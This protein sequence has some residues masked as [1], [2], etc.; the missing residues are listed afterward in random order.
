MFVRLNGVWI[1]KPSKIWICHFFYGQTFLFVALWVKGTCFFFIHSLMKEARETSQARWWIEMKKREGER[2]EKKL[3]QITQ[4][5]SKRIKGSFWNGSRASFFSSI[6]SLKVFHF[7]TEM[8]V[9]RMRIFAFHVFFPLSPSLSYSLCILVHS[10]WSRGEKK[11]AKT[12][13]A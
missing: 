9:F 10:K 5:T 2:E 1:V 11:T 13:L 6:F 12:L 8:D 7:T 4:I 3:E